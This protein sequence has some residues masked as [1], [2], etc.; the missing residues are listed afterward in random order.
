MC[1]ATGRSAS[2]PVWQVL[3][4]ETSNTGRYGWAYR[5]IACIQPKESLILAPASIE[6]K[7]LTFSRQRWTCKELGTVS[8]SGFGSEPT[9]AWKPILNV[10]PIDFH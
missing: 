9:L 1:V 4:Y 6:K 7:L 2:Y 8:K 10:D 5:G 3:Y